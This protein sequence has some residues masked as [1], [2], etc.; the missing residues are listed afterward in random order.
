VNE[1]LKIYTTGE[2]YGTVNITLMIVNTSPST[3]LMLVYV[4]SAHHSLVLADIR[5]IAKNSLLAMN[6]MTSSRKRFV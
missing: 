1:V 2:L 6:L 4:Q 3:R 5:S